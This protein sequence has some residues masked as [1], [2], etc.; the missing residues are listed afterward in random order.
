MSVSQPDP[1]SAAYDGWKSIVAKYQKPDV[2][3]SVWQIVNSFGGLLVFWVLMYF[4]LNVGYWLTL[5]LSVPAAGFLV[6][7][8]IIQH[9]CGHGSFFSSRKAN[10]AVGTACSMFTFVAYKYWRKSS[11]HSS[12]PSRGIWKSVASGMSGP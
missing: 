4:S 7:I 11:C 3:K 10:D 5:L 6:R 1:A 12:C 9:D 8:F 2:Q